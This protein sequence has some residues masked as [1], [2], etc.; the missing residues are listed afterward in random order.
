MS[1]DDGRTRVFISYSHDSEAHRGNLL[2]LAQSLRRNGLNVVIDQYSESTPPV[3]W[4][5]WM[6]EQ[7]VDADFVLVVFSEAYARRFLGKEEPGKGFGA[8]WEGAL[9][10]SYLYYSEEDRVKFVPA[11]VDASDAR[12]IPAPLKLTTWY[13]IGT[14]GSRELERLLRHLLRQPAVLPEP[15]G[16]VIDLGAQETSSKS[17]NEEP[18]VEGAMALA[19]SGDTESAKRQLEDLLSS[20]SKL[21]RGLAAYNLGRL[22]QQEESY[23]Q[24][25]TSYQRALELL[26]NSAAATAAGKNLQTAVEQMNNHYGEGGPVAAALDWLRSIRQGNIRHAWQG[27][28]GE[29]RLALAQAWIISNANHPNLAN[30]SREEIAAELSVAKPVT[31]LSR[32][33]LATQLSEF[34]R[35][36]QAFD[37]E[38]WGAA[39]KPRR[40]GLDYE[41]VIFMATGGDV[42]VWQPE[43]QAQAV[44]LLLKRQLNRWYV[45]HFS[46]DLIVPGWPPSRQPLP[47]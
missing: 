22:W 27:L 9:I 36:F 20:A 41:L 32:A 15:I 25:I 16:P 30:R 34:Q 5:Q 45:A 47:N 33:F 11:V 42:L 40:Y 46:P 29:T 7:I 43:M 1:N 28:T 2:D 13:A 19:A 39:E 10:T 12:I 18:A 26:P 4:P 37:D 17:G 21:T 24:A 35:A 14:P 38:T 44:Q 31:R 3:S 6:Q 23:G 8:R